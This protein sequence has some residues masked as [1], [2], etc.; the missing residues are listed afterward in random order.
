MQT[1][2]EEKKTSL[3]YFEETKSRD[4]CRDICFNKGVCKAFNYIIK[5]QTCEIIGIPKSIK[6]LE[7]EME[8]DQ[9]RAER[10]K[11]EKEALVPVEII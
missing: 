1:I 11:K 10:V 3:L 5:Y 9:E 2:A 7:R 4:V 6:D 8:S